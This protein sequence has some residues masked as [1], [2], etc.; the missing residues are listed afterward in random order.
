M[1]LDKLCLLYL[2]INFDIL[3]LKAQPKILSNCKL[4]ELSEA[5]VISRKRVFIIFRPKFL[6]DLFRAMIWGQ[7]P[8]HVPTT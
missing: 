5:F 2:A 7:W 6:E 3:G 4:V 8:G 1:L